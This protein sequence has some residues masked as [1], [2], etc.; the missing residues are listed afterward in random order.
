[1][2]K[3]KR[4]TVL[5]LAIVMLVGLVPAPA[6]AKTGTKLIALT[7]DD[8]PS[9]AYTPQLL[10][11]LKKR[12]AHVSFFVTGENAKRNPSIVKRAWQEGHQICSHTY[13][14]TM[15]SSLSD[16]EIKADLSK[17]NKIIDEA[18]GI[19]FA[20][21]LRPP[22]GDYNKRVLAAVNTPCYYWSVDTRDWES[23][24]TNAAYNQFIRAAKDGSIVLMH[25]IHKT[26]IPA[27]LKAIDTLQAQGYEFVTLNEL[28][29]RRGI[30]PTAG[31][32]YFS[33]Y[34][35]SYGTDPGIQDPVISYKDSSAGKRVFIT[36]DSRAKIYYTT[37]GTDPMPYKSK[38]YKGSFAVPDGTTVK[39]ICVIY[40]NSFRSKVV[41][42][43]IQ[44]TS[45][46]E[47]TIK[48]ESGKISFG[49]LPEGTT[50][51]YTTNGTVP[52]ESSIKYTGKITA[53]PGTVYTV[54]G[55]TPGYRNGGWSWLTYSE[56]GKTYSDAVPDCWYY[57]DTD[58][59]I[60]EGLLDYNGSELDAYST[61][62]RAELVMMLYRLA[63]TPP[64]ETEAAVF[65]DVPEKG[66][67]IDA[68][69]WAYAAGITNGVGEDRFDPAKEVSREQMFAMLARYIR[70]DGSKMIR[71]D[72]SCLTDF[73]DANE[74]EPCLEDDVSAMCAS[75]IV[76]G[77]G[78]GLLCPKAH[79]RRAEA[80]S[81]LV[82]T[83][84]FLK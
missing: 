53:V 31:K 56:F 38:Q 65:V 78:N 71:A 41:T 51:Y 25:D 72:K 48:V 27:A 67:Y 34:P 76:R 5:A 60:S 50:Y 40:W 30:T 16:S 36:G 39:A 17:T 29:V 47:P 61:V 57:N 9:A 74:L 62:T 21:Q 6:Q 82:R 10:D 73:T 55:Y 66:S 26:T 4:V 49:G 7:F 44:Y 18:I 68:V 80:A 32:I 24:N 13:K 45:L 77:Y 35:D 28:L 75:G 2:K 12:G 69:E 70:W 81:A 83:E 14:H 11:G 22:Y 84:D 33:A 20:Y 46:K 3:A 64:I 42:K 43:K 8:G 63:G 58:R 1:M 52:D 23:L 15:L 19:D 37:D 59:A 54:R 79:V